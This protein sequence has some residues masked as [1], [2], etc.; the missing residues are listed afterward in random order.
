MRDQRIKYIKNLVNK[1]Q[2]F[3]RNKAVLFSKGD[4]I[5]IIDPDDLLLNDIIIKVYKTAKR[6][7]LDI[8]QY[9][10]MMGNVTN[11]YLFKKKNISGIFYQPNIKNIF[12]RIE[13]RYL[14]DKLI[15]R[16]I[17]I[18]S[19]YFM[20]KKFRKER[21]SIHNDDIACFGLFRVAKSYGF[22]EEIGYFYNRENEESTHKIN[23][24][25]K[26]INRRF[27]SIFSTM[28]YY[29]E[30][31]DDNKYEKIMGGYNFFK[32]RFDKKSYE[33]IKFLTKDFDYI[34]DIL[35]LYIK[36][37]YYNNTQ[38]KS[39][40]QLRYKIIQQKLKIKLKNK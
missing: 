6:Y 4:Y 24:K 34:I 3:S 33:K 23:Y 19:I 1:G 12:F 10:N 38:K 39:L 7:N 20:H 27:R 26:Y 8:V 25:K 9:H 32:L 31:T 40:K 29:Y 13:D 36:S 5:L 28:K 37:P 2:F 14:W 15:K 18:K 17:F 16:K 11:N 21:F 30:Q 22:L 35:D